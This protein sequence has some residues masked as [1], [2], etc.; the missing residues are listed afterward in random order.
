VAGYQQETYPS[1]V[2]FTTNPTR[3][4]LWLNAGP[5]AG[6]TTTN[7]LSY[8]TGPAAARIRAEVRSCGIYGEQ[9]GTGAG[10]FRVL[11]FPLPIITLTAPH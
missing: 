8:G 5:T 2:L 10:L 1:V 7:R 4:D 3:H 11:R 9:I 6:N